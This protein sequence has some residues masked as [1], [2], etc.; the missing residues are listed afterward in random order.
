MVGFAIFRDRPTS[1]DIQSFLDRAIRNADCSPKYIITDKGRQFW[2]DSFKRWCDRRV[3]RPRFG[4]V[5]KYGSIA[6]VE[7]FIRSMKNEYIKHI[8]IPLRLDGMRREL[9][10]YVIWYNMHCPNQALGGLT[11]WEEYTSVRPANIRLRFEPRRNWPVMSPCASPQTSIRG[12]RGTKLTL[13][14]G[15]VDGRQHLPVVELRQAA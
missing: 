12:K 6:I 10:S 9:G 5:G 8:L 2:C 3:I 14:V 4:A 15:Y 13:V 1:S 11:P 7:R